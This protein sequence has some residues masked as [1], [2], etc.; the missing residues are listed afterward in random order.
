MKRKRPRATDPNHVREN[1]DM[2]NVHFTSDLHIG[3]TTIAKLRCEVENPELWNSRTEDNEFD[4]WEQDVTNWHDEWLA[5][6]WDQTL[7]PGDIVW[8]LGDISAG[9]KT[10]QMAALQWFQERKDAVKRNWQRK[11]EDDVITIRLV[12]GNHDEAHPMHRDSY[13]W[14]P[15]YMQPKGPFQ[16]VQMSAR[17]RIPYDSEGHADAFLSHFP[18]HGDHGKE[19]YVQYRLPDLGRDF[20]LHGHTHS[21]KRFGGRQLHVG[22]DAWHGALVPFE[23]IVAYVNGRWEVKPSAPE[24]VSPVQG[25]GSYQDMAINPAALS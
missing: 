18:Y 21:L 19:R 9:T 13:K 15:I 12:A 24:I 23:S 17:V 1:E 7:R 8:V 10:A 20:I 4:E 14:Q 6:I 11:G 2:S 16:S 22:V 25:M 3:H 5:G